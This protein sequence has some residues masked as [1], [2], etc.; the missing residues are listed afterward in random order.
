MPSGQSSFY[1]KFSNAD[2]GIN[3]KNHSSD[4]KRFPKLAGL[5]LGI[6]FYFVLIRVISGYPP[7]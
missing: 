5:I 4:N 1:E 2:F 6:L 3:H 7:H